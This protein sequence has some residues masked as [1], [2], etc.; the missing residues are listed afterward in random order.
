[1]M[2]KYK[3]VFLDFIPKELND[4]YREYAL[5]DIEYITMESSLTEDKDRKSKRGGLL[6]NG[7]REG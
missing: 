7:W 1:M 4:I 2:A 5:P 6:Y 3:A